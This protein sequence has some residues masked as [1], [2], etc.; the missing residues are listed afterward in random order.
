MSQSFDASRSLT[1]L[2]QDN[3]IVVCGCPRK[4]KK[5][6]QTDFRHAIRCSRVSGL[7]VRL[8]HGRGP[9]WRYAGSGPNRRSGLEAP[10]IVLVFPIPSL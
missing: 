3:T 4:C 2:E 6:F 7:M 10:T 5:F 1:A 9:V 8:S